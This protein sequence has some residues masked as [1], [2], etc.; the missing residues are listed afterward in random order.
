MQSSAHD[1]NALQRP[2]LWGTRRVGPDL[3]H[4]GRLRSND[5]HVAHFWDPQSVSPGSVM[6]PYPWFFREGWEV[7]RSIDPDVKVT[8]DQIFTF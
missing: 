5:W 6:P 7:R 1:N 3:T 4:E 2:V 8:P